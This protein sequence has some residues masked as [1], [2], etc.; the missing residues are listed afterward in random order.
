MQVIRIAA[1]ARFI[2]FGFETY[3]GARHA[4]AVHAN[5]FFNTRAYLQKTIKSNNYRLCEDRKKE[6][7]RHK[8]NVMK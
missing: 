4:E 3:F 8:K 1:V 5:I 6:A 2:R 7:K